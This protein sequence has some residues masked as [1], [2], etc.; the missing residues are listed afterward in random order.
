[1]KRDRQQWLIILYLLGVRR[2]R[3]LNFGCV[4]QEWSKVLHWP[5]TH[6]FSCLYL[7]LNLLTT[8]IVAP[9]SNASKWQVGFNSAF[10]GLNVKYWTRFRS[11]NIYSMPLYEVWKWNIHVN[12]K[13]KRPGEVMNFQRK[14]HMPI[15]VNVY[16][17]NFFNLCQ[18]V[19]NTFYDT[20][21]KPNWFSGYLDMTVALKY[22]NV[23]VMQIN[24]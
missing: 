22:F 8:T 3:I 18:I 17:R 13:E 21:S 1:M 14:F 2:I 5:H 4:C 19:G 11:V 7:T 20:P 9:P 12:V 16:I 24:P 15:Q 23:N 10:K 6:I